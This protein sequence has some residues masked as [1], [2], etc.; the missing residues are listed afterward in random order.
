MPDVMCPPAGDA[1][2]CS[3][4]KACVLRRPRSRIV[5]ILA[6]AIGLRYTSG[7]GLSLRTPAVLSGATSPGSFSYANDKALHFLGESSQCRAR[8]PGGHRGS[9]PRGR[10]THLITCKVSTPKRYGSSVSDVR[11]G[12]ATSD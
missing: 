10:H 4:R 1:G 8:Q 9:R 5:F 7:F 6:A 11:Q 12:Y 3:L 2:R